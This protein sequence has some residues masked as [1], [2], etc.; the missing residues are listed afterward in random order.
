MSDLLEGRVLQST[1][2]RSWTEKL[3]E[4]T[5]RIRRGLQR[6]PYD[7][8]QCNCRRYERIYP[9]FLAWYPSPCI[10]PALLLEK[11][12]KSFAFSMTIIFPL[13][14]PQEVVSVIALNLTGDTYWRG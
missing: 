14:E 5:M 11:N 6:R 7:Y 10:A 2:I 12:S 9:A 1:R 4:V 8:Q 3:V 13:V